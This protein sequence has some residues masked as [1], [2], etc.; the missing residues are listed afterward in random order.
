VKYKNLNLAFL[1]EI[2]IGF[3]CILSISLLGNRGLTSLVLI[4][5]RPIFLEKEL[6][7]DE[8]L[9]WQFS[10]KILLNS[11]IIIALMIISILII[12]QFIPAWKTRL[13]SSEILF[14]E[15]IPF[16][17]LTHGVIGFVNVSSLDRKE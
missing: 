3:G 14:I 13:P 4:A 8:K 6:I 7:K 2:L 15:I 9:Y 16:F 5:L 12:V 11:I 1:F 10:Y 17:I